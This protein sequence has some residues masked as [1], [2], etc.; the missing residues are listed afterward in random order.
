MSQTDEKK[1]IRVYLLLD[2][3]TQ[4]I[5]KTSE[6]QMRSKLQGIRKDIMYQKFPRW[7]PFAGVREA[8]TDGMGKKI[9]VESWTWEFVAD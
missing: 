4:V 3:S 9:Q 6:R 7:A 5:V 2:P 8:T 1:T